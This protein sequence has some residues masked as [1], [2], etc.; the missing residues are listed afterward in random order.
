MR[1]N[2]YINQIKCI[3]WW[4]SDKE[5]FIIDLLLSLPT[6]AEWKEIEWEIYYYL[7]AWALVK[8]LPWV[9]ESKW[10]FTNWIKWLKEKWL[11]EHKIYKNKWWYKITDKIKEWS[12]VTNEWDKVSPTSETSVTSQWD[13]NNINNNINNNS[14]AEE[15]YSFYIKTISPE[16]K[17][18]KKAL[19]I[20]R[21]KKALKN[22]DKE[23]ILTII[24]TYKKEKREDIEK[25]Y[26]KAPQ[27]FFGAVERGSKVMYYEE[28]KGREEKNIE[29]DD[30]L[31]VF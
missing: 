3:E 8:Q 16:K 26:A 18:V 23:T 15:I 12:S 29:I 5:A 1:Y 17:W 6:W 9:S 21:I 11:I 4:L 10:S 28:F 14:E 27:Y 13:N 2:I 30:S 19:S 24:K 31:L 25:G 20:E 7:S 22:E